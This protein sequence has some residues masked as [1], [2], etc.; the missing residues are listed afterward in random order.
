MLCLLPQLI[1]LNLLESCF[2]RRKLTL[3]YLFVCSVHTGTWH[4]ERHFSLKISYSTSRWCVNMLALSEIE[5]I[6]FTVGSMVLCSGFVLET[7]LI[8]Q[9]CFHSCWAV[10]TQHQGFFCF[11]C[12]LTSKWAGGAQGAGREHRQNNWPPLISGVF[13]GVMVGIHSWGKKKEEGDV[14]SYGISLPK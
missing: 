7:V 4:M 9:G 3:N 5:V 14:G 2:W 1:C 13:H 8:T 12:H 10:L 11:S 6:F